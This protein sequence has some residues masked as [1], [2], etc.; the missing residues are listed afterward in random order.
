MHGVD[1]TGVL[2]GNNIKSRAIAGRQNLLQ[3][4]KEFVFAI[5][6]ACVSV[7]I[8]DEMTEK[9]AAKETVDGA[10]ELL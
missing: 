6:I 8:F 1:H 4:R 9:T 2:I 5:S 10:V 7:E 3:M